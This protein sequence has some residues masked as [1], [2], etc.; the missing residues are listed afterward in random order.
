VS[1]CAGSEMGRFYRTPAA[2]VATE[3]GTNVRTFGPADL[4]LKSATSCGGIATLEEPAAQIATSLLKLLGEV[5]FDPPN[6]TV[7][8]AHE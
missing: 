1:A 6:E 2:S 3:T 4:V 5:V 8:V 7:W